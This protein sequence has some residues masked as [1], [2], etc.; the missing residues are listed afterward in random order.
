MEQPSDAEAE[1]AAAP[2]E[3]L[4]EEIVIKHE[5]GSERQLYGTPLVL[6]LACSEEGEGNSLPLTDR[7]LL[8]AQCTASARTAVRSAGHGSSPVAGSARPAGL[9]T[10]WS[11][12]PDVA[13][14]PRGAVRLTRS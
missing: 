7:L 4:L 9:R 11:V 2:W 12:R 10:T 3:E 13:P 6:A 5:R 14:L 8:A 1:A